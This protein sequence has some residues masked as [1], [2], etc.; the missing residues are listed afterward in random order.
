MLD[1]QYHLSF[2]ALFDKNSELGI[3]YAQWSMNYM[4]T[5]NRMFLDHMHEQF[6]AEGNGI[7]VAIQDVD[8]AMYREYC[9]KIRGVRQ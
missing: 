4:P 9:L 7:T 1:L 6:C 5:T 2:G 8:A 3:A